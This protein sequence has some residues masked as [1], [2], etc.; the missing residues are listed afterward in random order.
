MK[1]LFSNRT[2]LGIASIILALIISFGI[3]PLL[4]KSASAQVE[5]IKASQ[6][7]EAGEIISEDK[8]IK[9]K[10]GAYNLPKDIIVD[11]NDLLGKYAKTD[12]YKDDFFLP[13]KITDVERL[14]NYY[15][16]NEFNEDL[17][18]SLTIKSL[19]SGLSGKLE[20]GDIITI[21]SSTETT[22]PEIIPEL[23][24]VKVLSSTTG[25]GLD[26]EENKEDLPS[27]ITIAVNDIQAEKAVQH[28]LLGELHVALAYRGD[29]EIAQS[30]LDIQHEYFLYLEDNDLIDG[31]YQLSYDY[32]N[33]GSYDDYEDIADNNT[34]NIE[35]FIKERIEEKYTKTSLESLEI[36]DEE[37]FDLE[38]EL[39]WLQV[40][41]L[42]ITKKIIEMYSDDLV[43]HLTKSYDLEK[44]QIRWNVP[45]HLK[46]KYL[47]KLDY[48][49]E[50]DQLI[51]NDKIYNSENDM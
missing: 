42:A 20:Y 47:L 24:Y 19:A 34:E 23:M 12:I 21:I 5:V 17:A 51:L 31:I 39:T 14:D 22:A 18:I 13:G 49:K 10:I 9:I 35:S 15:L 50:G 40:N 16:H 30:Y 48:D 29:E 38:I 43:K 28:E 41:D 8:L 26:K 4:N 44:L 45:N 46:D 6:N 1:K 37:G 33:Y 25:E 2:T 27:T 32:D 7:I 11:Q 3:T 36:N